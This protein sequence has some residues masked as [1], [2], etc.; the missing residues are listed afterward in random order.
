M[1]IKAQLADGTV[2]EFEDGTPDSVIDR[3]VR[4]HTVGAPAAPTPVAAPADA[5]LEPT[6][7]V[8]A[9]AP[10]EGGLDQVG[11]ETALAKYYQ[12]LGGKPLDPA[13]IST[14]AEKYNVGTPTNLS[15]VEEFYKTQGQLNPSLQMTGPAAPPPPVADPAEI[16][17]TVPLADANTQRARAFGKGLLFDFADELEAA[18]RMVTSGEISSDEYYRIKNQINADYGTWAK[19]H[20]GEALGMEVSGGIAGAFIPGIGQVGTG[21]RAARAGNA[22]RGVTLAGAKSG[23]ISGGL[24]GFGQANTL[25]PSDLIP[26]VVGGA[27]T[28]GVAGG[29][30][31]K[32]VELAG[33]GFAIGRDAVLRRLGRAPAGADAVERKTAEVLY[34]ST[35][36]PE[37]AVGATALS[38]KYGVPTPLGLA[39]PE[40][41]ALTE[42]VLAKPSSGR[43]GLATELAETQLG[44]K[45]RVEDQIDKAL[46]GS[47]DYFDAE[48]AITANLRKIGN[49]EY[50]QAFAVGTVNDRHITDIVNNPQ[51]SSIW[52]QAKDLA[53]LEGRPL[54]LEMEPVLDV[55]GALVGI[56]PTGRNLPDVEAL[57]FFKR[58]LDDTIEAGFRGNA[59]VGKARAASLREN[60]RTPLMARLDTVVPEYKTARALYAGD[61][62][63]RDALRLGRDVLKTKMRPQQLQREMANMSNAERE[64]LKTGARQSIFE[65]FED[66]TTSRNF[67]QRLR[68]VRGDSAALQ[69]LKMVIDPAEFKFFSRALQREDELFKRGSRVMGGSRTTPLAAGMEALDDLVAKQD[70]AG[71]VNFVMAPTPG[72]IAALARFVSKLDPGKEFGDKVYT[73]LSQVL[74]A[75]E[76]DKLRDVLDMLMRSRSYGQYMAKV[77]SMAAGP[78]AGVAGNVAPSAFEDRSPMVPPTLQTGEE[79]APD[80]VLEQ[81]QRVLDQPFEDSP[82]LQFEGAA[83]DGTVP[84][85]GNSLGERNLNR[86]N[87]I[88]GPWARKQPGYVGPGEG[89]F[90]RFET[91]AAGDAAQ[92]RLIA[93]KVQGGSNTPGTLVE[94][95]LGRDPRNTP[96]S[97]AAYKAYVAQRLG[98]GI[99]DRISSDMIPLASRAMIEFE[100][101]ARAR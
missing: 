26:S 89:G 64:A 78:V 10:D 21:L 20:P 1:P 48:D 45:A 30:M 88:D 76:P 58:A 27:L 17:R 97:T 83:E 15:E 37:R 7:P 73:K 53:E 94:S 95:Y 2:L 59:G 54:A 41:T 65:P 92:R 46:P 24:S 18:G 82:G 3:V 85:S 67:A 55:T 8:A 71:M 32:G 47:Q 101:G 86:G 68:G 38:A 50:Q 34:G 72:R 16:V 79:A 6:A 35:P 40:L 12:S 14:L 91:A 4:E 90:A 49:N 22:L 66:A 98:I 19:A 33:K 96:E 87:I 93:G 28:G 77:K 44:A 100:T 74:S 60:I 43:Q 61:M 11:F 84:F 23:A 81:A 52:K 13:V 62:E 39:T 75:N 9:A 36:S 31:G 70:I 80:D 69:K 5:P 29:A 57:H 63:V 51:L 56:K 99:G 25:A 42:K